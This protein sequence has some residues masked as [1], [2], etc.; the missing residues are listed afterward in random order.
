MSQER[1]I[2]PSLSA[3]LT[4]LLLVT[5]SGCREELGPETFPIAQVTGIVTE[6][7]R[8]L[9]R[10]WIEFVPVDGTVGNLRSGWIQPDGSFQV[11]RVA[12]GENAIRLVHAGI[13]LP[14]FQELVGNFSTPI[15]RSIQARPTKALKIDVLEESV[16]FLSARAR[17][18]MSASSAPGSGGEP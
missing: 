10:G 15:R 6:G 2:G 16:R 18:R 4:V 13:Q 17:L 14:Q 9:N 5:M 12:I 7:S 1:H 11:D 8:P 3:R